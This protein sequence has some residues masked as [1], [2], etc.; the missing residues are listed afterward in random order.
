[1]SDRTVAADTPPPEDQ[2]K[3]QLDTR[4]SGVRQEN[5]DLYWWAAALIE[6]TFLSLPSDCFLLKA[7]F[8]TRS[9]FA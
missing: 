7:L 2:L 9:G 4:R 8:E 3:V 6:R 1:M 5:S